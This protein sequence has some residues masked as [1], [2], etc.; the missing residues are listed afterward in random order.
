MVVAY[1]VICSRCGCLFHLFTR[2]RSQKPTDGLKCTDCE[3]ETRQNLAHKRMLRKRNSI[4]DREPREYKRIFL[5]YS[6]EAHEILP[7]IMGVQQ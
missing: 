5:G 2:D 3:I 1:E 6:P 7:R 4:P